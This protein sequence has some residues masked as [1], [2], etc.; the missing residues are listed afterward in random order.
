MDDFSIKE[1]GD[2]EKNFKSFSTISAEIPI[3][4]CGLPL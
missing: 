4:F 2:R 3:A 1:Y